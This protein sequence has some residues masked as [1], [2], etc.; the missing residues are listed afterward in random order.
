MVAYL[1]LDAGFT[2]LHTT[3]ATIISIAT[4]TIAPKVVVTRDKKYTDISPQMQ[5]LTR[6]QTQ[7]QTQTQ[8]QKQTPTQTQKYTH[9]RT[10][11]HA[12]WC[13]DSMFAGG[14]TASNAPDL[15]RPPKLSGAGPG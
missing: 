10:H 12:R 4:T 7:T 13:A 11:T 14:H 2:F 5:R 6:A 15:F 3:A 8:T 1:H 9:A